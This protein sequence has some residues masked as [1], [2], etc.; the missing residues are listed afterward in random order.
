MKRPTNWVHYVYA[1]SALLIV[2]I[3]FI[4]HDWTVRGNNSVSGPQIE[5]ITVLH[6]AVEITI[7]G[8]SISLFLFLITLGIVGYRKHTIPAPALALF[9]ALVAL[10]VSCTKSILSNPAQWTTC[11]KIYGPDGKTF[12]FMDSSLLKVQ[13][14]A[15][16]TLSRKTILTRYMKVL[17]AA[18]GGTPGSFASIV[19]P[20]DASD[21][22]GQVY[23]CGNRYLI[24]VRSA[25]E[26]YL[27]YDLETRK[28]YGRGTIEEISPFICIGDDTAVKETDVA[29]LY[30]LGIGSGPGQPRRGSIVEGLKHPNPLIREISKHL[31]EAKEKTGGR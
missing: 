24:G 7:A 31:I 13:T 23:L 20:A 6:P 18:D 3:A 22:Y 14:M 10:P 9:L 16:T 4:P 12:Y 15:L 27:A 17:V 28:G 26:C 2:L 25:N 5:S 30:R 11:S 1:V 8:I 29:N 19:R 21:S